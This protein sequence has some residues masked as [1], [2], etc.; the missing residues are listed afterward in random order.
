MQHWHSE[1]MRKMDILHGQLQWHVAFHFY[2]RLHVMFMQYFHAN[3]AA[4]TCRETSSID[5]Q[6]GDMDMEHGHEAWMYSIGM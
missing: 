6:H 1:W 3:H 4:W 5:M 2:L